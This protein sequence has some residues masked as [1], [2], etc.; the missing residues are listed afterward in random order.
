[1]GSVRAFVALELPSAIQDS[2]RK[3][4][5][6]LQV[7]TKGLPLRLVPVEKIHITL[8]FLGDMDEAKVQPISDL[9]GAKA[10][11]TSA[12][13]IK[14]NGMGVFPSPRRPNVIWVGVIA[15]A[16]LLDLQS[17]VEGELSSLGF[18]PE[19]RPFSAHLTI[20]RVRREARPADLQR[21][22]EIVA[23]TDVAAVTG[24]IDTLT[25]FQSQLKPSG[26]VYNPLSRNPLA[27]AI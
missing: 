14:L 15:P 2:L 17:Q 23:S 20:A 25:L 10:K 5:A 13:D 1:M 3:I 12:F 7:K 16:S 4:S 8:K 24:R 19:K 26:S 9:L 6:D 22:A 18:V 11:S 21:I 27:A